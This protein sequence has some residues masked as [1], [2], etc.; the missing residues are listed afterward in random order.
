MEKNAPCHDAID[1]PLFYMNDFSVLGLLVESLTPV[2][3]ALE[4]DG[5]QVDH[6]GCS[7]KVR[8]KNDGQLKKI[9]NILQQTGIDFV[10]SDLV[11]CAYQG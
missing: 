3:T 11:D 10:M 6:I 9:F 5:Y 4:N 2:V 1:W 8:F 7:A